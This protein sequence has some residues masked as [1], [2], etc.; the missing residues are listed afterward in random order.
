M[1]APVKKKN[2]KKRRSCAYIFPASKIPK[3]KQHII[4][5]ALTVMQVCSGVGD[6]RK[7]SLSWVDDVVVQV[8][9]SHDYKRKAAWWDSEAGRC[10]GS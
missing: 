5:N 10:S 6:K 9:E 3:P 4:T 1:L 7:G 8:V 2:K